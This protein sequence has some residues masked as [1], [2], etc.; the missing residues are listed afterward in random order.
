MNIIKNQINKKPEYINEDRKINSELVRLPSQ[1]LEKSLEFIKRSYDQCKINYSK[2]NFAAVMLSGGLDS[3]TALAGAIEAL[4]EKN[5]RAVLMNHNNLTKG[6]IEDRKFA[7]ELISYYGVKA[8]EIDITSMI[9][10]HNSTLET[11]IDAETK[12]NEFFY[13]IL[14][15]ESIARS[16]SNAMELYSSVNECITIDTSNMTELALGHITTGAYMG[17]VE[18]FEDL[19]KC[20]VYKVAQELKLPKF[21]LNREKTISEFS[22]TGKE[23][24]G[25]DHLVLDP[26][27]HRYISGISYETTLTELGHD[28]KWL[29]YVWNRIDETRFRYS[30]AGPISRITEFNENKKRENTS[31]IGG[32]RDYWKN[33]SESNELAKEIQ[34][35]REVYMP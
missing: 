5:V 24:H 6:E 16:R 28:E 12:S 10:C 19:L 26:I 33:I 35:C 32:M 21:I 9:S 13:E 23:M 27:V 17:T 15:A 7:K 4:G 2:P 25:A 1:Y 22:M 18:F 11:I 29:S 34:T 30:A 14:K 31:W 20:E 8:D 3:A